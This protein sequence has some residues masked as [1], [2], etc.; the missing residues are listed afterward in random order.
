MSR[1]VQQIDVHGR[2]HCNSGE[3]NDNKDDYSFFNSDAD[4]DV[5]T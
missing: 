5:M 2:G 3:A 1:Y 4:Y